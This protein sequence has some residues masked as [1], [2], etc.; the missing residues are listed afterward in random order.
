MTETVE[1]KK[2]DYE[3]LEFEEGKIFRAVNDDDTGIRNAAG[4][5]VDLVSDSEIAAEV[6]KEELEAEK[7]KEQEVQAQ[8]EEV[9]E[10]E[11][12][13]FSADEFE[14]AKK[15]A[16]QEGLAEGLKMAKE[17]QDKDAM[18]VQSQ[19]NNLLGKINAQIPAAVKSMEG[20]FTEIEKQSVALAAKITEKV[21]NKKQA[22]DIAE[23]IEASIKD[24]LSKIKGKAGLKLLVNPSALSKIEGK[25]KDVEL[26]GDEAILPADFKIEWQNGFMQ[27]K[28]DVIW[29]EIA[30]II[31]T[32]EIEKRQKP[33]AK[34]V[35][36]EVKAEVIVE[37][38]AQPEAKEEVQPAKPEEE[39]V[40]EAE[41]EEKNEETINL[42]KENKDV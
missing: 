13:T 14:M 1:I 33:A 30:Q 8:P 11:A 31:D 2:Y 27:K 3:M 26:L 22:E 39:V 15:L 20:K 41:N 16:K 29:D 36:A 7:A 17:Q 12:P 18:E 9:K 42:D 21:V 34:E 10:P 37:E 19:I 32:G 25:F 24:A 6:A 23:E 5:A 4:E 35:K 40:L 28:T 38:A